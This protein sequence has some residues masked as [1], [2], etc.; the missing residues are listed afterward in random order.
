MTSL[1]VKTGDKFGEDLSAKEIARVKNGWWDDKVKS[2][3]ARHGCPAPFQQKVVDEKMN[4]VPQQPCF[5]VRVMAARRSAAAA[6][7]L[8]PIPFELKLMVVTIAHAS[9][10]RTSG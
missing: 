5:A 4:N 2:D 6:Q 1:E 8:N 10:T 7:P 3:D 9:S